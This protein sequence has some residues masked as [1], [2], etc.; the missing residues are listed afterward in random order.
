[1]TEYEL[2]LACYLSGQMDESQWQRHLSDL[3]F[4]T[5]LL[6]RS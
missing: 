1:M 4:K 6:G 5:W 2:T 3:A